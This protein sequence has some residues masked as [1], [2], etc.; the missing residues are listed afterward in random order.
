MFKT[1][2]NSRINQIE[3]NPKWFIY[4][5]K[6]FAHRTKQFLKNSRKL[7]YEHLSLQGIRAL[8]WY[9]PKRDYTTQ[10]YPCTYYIE[11]ERADIH[12]EVGRCLSFTFNK[13]WIAFK[14]SQIDSR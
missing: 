7:Y 10:N 6:R 14:K 5:T 2:V 9:N 11:I 8:R 12:T 3:M 4:P 1:N 13:Y